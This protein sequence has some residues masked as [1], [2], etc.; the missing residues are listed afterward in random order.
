MPSRT[1]PTWPRTWKRIPSA[2]AVVNFTPVLIEQIQELARRIASICSPERRCRIRCSDCWVR[3]PLPQE[4]RERLELLRACLRAQRKQMIERFGPYLELATIAET[5]ATPERVR[6]A[7]DQL[8]HDLAV[9]YHLAWLGETVRRSHP[10]VSALTEQG[11]DFTPTQ[12]RQLL[13][14]DRGSGQR[15]HPALSRARRESGTDASFVTPYAHP[16]I[17]LLLDFQCRTRCRS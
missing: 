14:V 10:L 9:W 3:T 13:D 8:I 4:P 7:S 1:T 15:G 16:I 17:P 12:R 2:R 6:Y 5:L 11:R